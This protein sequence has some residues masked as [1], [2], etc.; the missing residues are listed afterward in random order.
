MLT[1][2]HIFATQYTDVMK[3]LLFTFSYQF[4]VE[5]FQLNFWR[6]FK[7]DPDPFYWSF[8]KA[9]LHCVKPPLS[10]SSIFQ[11]Q[12]IVGSVLAMLDHLQ[13]AAAQVKCWTM[14]DSRGRWMQS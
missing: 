11:S 12:H 2:V 4:K 10:Y 14:E 8:S 6:A 1:P 9:K 13:L 3:W 5:R 7:T